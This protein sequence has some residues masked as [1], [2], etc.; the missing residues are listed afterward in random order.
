ML[1]RFDRDQRTQRGMN[2]DNTTTNS[3][4][5]GIVDNFKKPSTAIAI[6]QC[7]AFLI[8]YWVFVPLATYIANVII[9]IILSIFGTW[10]N[11]NIL[12]TIRYTFTPIVAGG[13]I[14]V[15][16]MYLFKNYYYNLVSYIVCTMYVGYEIINYLILSAS[17]S[18]VISWGFANAVWYSAILVG[19]LFFGTKD[20]VLLGKSVVQIPE[21]KPIVAPSSDSEYDIKYRVKLILR[22]VLAVAVGLCICFYGSGL[23]SKLTYILS[24]K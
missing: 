21:E 3:V 14:V 17:Y 11:T 16:M 2:M 13:L 19:V 6:L 24:G 10:A 7:I 12:D 22:I 20:K 1:G 4:Q 5:E 9:S 23:Y 18:G 8:L 15:C